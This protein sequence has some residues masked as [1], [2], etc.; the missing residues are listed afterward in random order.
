MKKINIGLIGFGTVGTGVVKILKKRSSLLSRRCGCDLVIKWI[1]DKDITSPR[2][3][4]VEKGILTTEVDKVINDPEVDIIVELI[5]TV[6]P[7]KEFII[8]SLKKGKS[9][10]TANKAVLANFGQEIFDVAEK[11]NVNILFEASVGG[12]I[13]II[14]ALRE[15]LIANKIRSIFGIINGTSNYILTKM[16]EKGLSFDEALR[17]AKVRGF[18][19]E[20]PSL[21]VEGV[22]SSHKLAILASLAFG[23]RIYLDDI[24]TEGITKITS[25]DLRYAGEF[26]YTVKLLAI[27]K[28]IGGALEARVHPTLI[29]KDNLLSDV[30]GAYNAIYVEGDLIG[31]TIFYGQGA[32]MMPA[33]SA[34][35]ADLVDLAMELVGRKER[36]GKVLSKSE[37]M[38]IRKMDEIETRYYIRFQAIDKPGVLAEISGILGANKISIAS[39][40]QKLRRKE[41]VV[42]IVMMTH[43]ARESNLRTAMAKIDKLRAIKEKSVVIRIEGKE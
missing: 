11:N 20:D 2:E 36:K 29:P 16:S 17:E 4:K 34:V 3:V 9:V 24:Y 8:S 26:G 12:G 18:A 1:A 22:D 32:G 37:G 23:K 21:D 38:R 33:A 13:P 15:G 39:C 5:G 41:R 25:G 10:V 19:E 31:G 7:A 6:H 35:V 40:I 27:A 28:Y 30:S 42:P 14:K 43:E